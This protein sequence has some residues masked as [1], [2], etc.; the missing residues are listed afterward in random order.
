MLDS[1]DTKGSIF[2]LITAF[3]HILSDLFIHP[4]NQYILYTYYVPSTVLGPLEY[5]SENKTKQIKLPGPPGVKI[6]MGRQAINIID[7][8][9]LLSSGIVHR[10]SV[11]FSCTI[12]VIS[13]F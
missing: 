1:I 10:F 9:L 5:A 12:S 13:S 6:L 3:N 11:F 4:F 8:F 2:P 7:L